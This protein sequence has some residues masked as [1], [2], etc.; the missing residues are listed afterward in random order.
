MK[1]LK[2]AVKIG[3]GFA[4]IL[5]IFAI[6]GAIIFSTN[7][8][9]GT[10]TERM[11]HALVPEGKIAATIQRETLLMMYAWRGYAFTR[12]NAFLEEGK[13]TITALNNAISQGEALASQRPD[14]VKLRELI[15]EVRAKA[16]Q[17]FQLADASV[18]ATEAQNKALAR[19]KDLA[20]AYL[21][22]CYDFLT[23]Q[24]QAM[25]K[26]IAE[27]AA[28][29]KLRERLSKITWIN[30]LIDLGNGVI[31]A[32]Y[33][34]VAER[35]VA[36]LDAALL[37]FDKITATLDKLR[38]ITRNDANI[39]QLEAIRQ[40]AGAYKNEML[41]L[42]KAW[43]E[44][45]SLNTQRTKTGLEVLAAAG[46]INDAGQQGMEDGAEAIQASARTMSTI[47]VGGLSLAVVLGILIALFLTR[48][49]TK[50]VSQGVDFARRLAEGDLTAHIDVDQ[51][52]EIG[53]L[54][55]ALRD[56]AARLRE[57]V[58]QVQAAADNVASG[59]EELSSSAQQ[60]SQGTTEQAA[61]IEEVSSSMEQMNAN[62]RQNA[63]N[64]MQTEKIAVQAAKDAQFSGQVVS[65]AVEAMKKIAEK[66]S[67]IEEIARQTNLLALNAAIEA[68][69]AGE[70]GKGFAVVAA[71][72]RKLAERSG[73]AAAEI[74][75]LSSSTV[76]VADQAG[77]M[78]AKLVPDIQRT[79]ELV[80]EISAAS[81][82]QSTGV[83][84]I[85]TAI[86]QLDQVVQQNAAAAE[87]MASTSEELSSQAEG[88]QNAIGFFHLGGSLG[89]KVQRIARRQAPKPAALPP[90]KA[91]PQA[92]ASK[93][94]AL[95]MGRDAEDD[96][97]ERF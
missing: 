72:V 95:D 92:V 46:K 66:I 81:K 71:E 35:N 18:V 88:L 1:N 36:I 78:L 12:D 87:Q 43:T 75:E 9:L 39:R 60:L 30:D 38:P 48:S 23:S 40:A 59:S 80:Q 79:A 53:I 10:G 57:V 54:A 69:R 15:P 8:T 52:D 34:G 19:A 14:L 83:T 17:Y 64:A 27:G 91:A 51:K 68:A 16:N 58:G 96:E 86:Q 65:Q 45:E 74:S 7:A 84:Q 33:Q 32:T 63:D 5:V 28:G 62:I 22:G 4:A 24:N 26:E 47:T 55:Q 97:F 50:P 76:G 49:I 67:I 82:E 6:V 41:T 3:T 77:Q 11:V 37:N 61:S 73:A 93:G 20:A 29:D 21:K 31:Q 85:N 42:H 94:V 90:Q 56:M 70:H 89:Q 2:L 44:L 13:K 25:D